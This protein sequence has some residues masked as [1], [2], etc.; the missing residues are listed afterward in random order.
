MLLKSVNTIRRLLLHKPTSLPRVDT[1]A[2]CFKTS[3][4]ASKDNQSRRIKST[5]YYVTA[6]GV[7][8]AGL[9][10]AAVPLYRM[11]CQ[12]SSKTIA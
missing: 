6:G 5:L 8:V 10:Y 12:V 7:L 11:F 3:G 4:N 2:R 1:F 9:S